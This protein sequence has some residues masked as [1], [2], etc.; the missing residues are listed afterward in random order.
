MDF[1]R[2][3]DDEVQSKAQNHIKISGDTFRSTKAS[4]IT[5]GI[6]YTFITQLSLFVL[7]L[8]LVLA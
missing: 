5:M 8:P 4:K 1:L 2:L 6:L 7:N 3:G